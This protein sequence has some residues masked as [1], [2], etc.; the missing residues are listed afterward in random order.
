MQ[1]ARPG[2]PKKQTLSVQSL[3]QGAADSMQALAQQ[4]KVRLVCQE[5][6]HDELVRGDLGQVRVA[7]IGLLRNAMEAAPAG[8]W[9]G[10][11]YQKK[12]ADALELIV[13][14]DGDGPAQSMREHLFDPFFSG[15]SAGRGRGLGLPT[16]WRLARQQGGDV[17][18]DGVHDKVTRFVLSLPLAT[19]HDQG[20]NGSLAETNGHNGVHAFV[21]SH[22]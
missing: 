21:E 16:A 18:F 8:G 1:F 4:R 17:R 7:L 11:R 22:S 3:I 14:D 13:E 20:A 6:G 2:S 15:R 19:L 12:D 9:A 10:V 5:L